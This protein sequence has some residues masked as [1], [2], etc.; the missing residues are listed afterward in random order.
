MIWLRKGNDM[1]MCVSISLLLQIVFFNFFIAYF[2]GKELSVYIFTR[3]L[4]FYYLFHVISSSPFPNS[5]GTKQA[6][7]YGTEYTL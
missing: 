3:F 1:T 2:I 4:R 6:V 7:F 5:T